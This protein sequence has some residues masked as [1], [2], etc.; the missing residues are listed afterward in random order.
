LI[1]CFL[2][3]EAAANA[4]ASTTGD[5]L[6]RVLT[7][8]CMNARLLLLLLGAAFDPALPNGL[9]TKAAAAVLLLAAGLT[10]SL[11]LPTAAGR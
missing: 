3:P 7:L 6:P 4:A 8:L 5:A 2:L 11:N 10:K 1:V 9:H